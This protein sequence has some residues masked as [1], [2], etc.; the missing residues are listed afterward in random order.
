MG[1]NRK[2]KNVPS[3]RSNLSRGG[4]P[5]SYRKGGTREDQRRFIRGQKLMERRDRTLVNI[6][7]GTKR[8][9]TPRLSIIDIGQRWTTPA[10]TKREKDGKTQRE[11]GA[12]REQEIK[13]TQ[14]G[15]RTGGYPAART[16]VST[17][18]SQADEKDIKSGEKV[19]KST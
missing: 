5:L 12:L 19:K 9:H 15:E 8:K 6:P 7:L 14:K 16:N 17:G 2:K 1:G 11:L 10:G 13:R 3:C 4:P 18:K